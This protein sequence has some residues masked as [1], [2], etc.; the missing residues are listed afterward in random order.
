MTPL[1]ESTV[2]VWGTVAFAVCGAAF[3]LWNRL[4]NAKIPDNAAGCPTDPVYAAIVAGLTLRAPSS[5]F[6]ERSKELHAR[7]LETMKAAEDKASAIPAFV[8]GSAGLLALA[9]G[10]DKVGPRAI[11]PQLCTSIA[12]LMLLFLLVLK[13]LPRRTRPINIESL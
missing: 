7:Y 10:T 5:T 11:T 2:R 12:Y 4:P 3:V 13:I 8:G 6:L 1:S 9:V